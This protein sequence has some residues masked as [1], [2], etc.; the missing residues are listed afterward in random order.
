MDETKRVIS[1]PEAGRWLGLGRSASYA[2]ALRGD[3]PVIKIGR[4]LCV[5]IVALTRMLEEAGRKDAE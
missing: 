4:K 5:P 2:A 1:V 3:L